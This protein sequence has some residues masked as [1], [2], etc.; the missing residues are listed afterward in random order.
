MPAIVYLFPGQGAQAVGMGRA[1]YDRFDESKE[2]YRKANKTLGFDVTA[3]CFEGPQEAL[4]KTETCQPALFTTSL[5]AYAAFRRVA[6]SAFPPIAAAGLS[7]G[8]LTALAAAEAFKLEDGFYLIKARGEAMAQCAASSKGAMLAVVG[9]ARHVVDDICRESGAWGA[10]YNAPDQVVLSGTTETIA[11]AEALAKE[12]GAKRAVKLEVAGAFHSPLM[13]PAAEAF[14]QAI[15]KVEVRAPKFPVVSNATALPV[16]DPAQ[17]PNLLVKQIV[18]PVRWDESM[19]GLVKAGMTAAVEFP[20]A[21]VLTGLLRKIDGSVKGI[22]VDSP[23]DFEK[24]SS[25]N[26]IS[27]GG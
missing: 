7:L 20:P 19:A 13:Q 8:E 10:N 21:R 27:K 14:K 4:T 3:M 24:L 1:F 15:S 17:I 2:I 12:R 18:S 16:Q 23:A 6:P 26:Q 25:I 9:L 11:K 22:A 5:A